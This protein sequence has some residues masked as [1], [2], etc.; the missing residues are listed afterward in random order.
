MRPVL[1]PAVG[2]HILMYFYKSFMSVPQPFLVQLKKRK[3]KNGHFGEVSSIR[4]FIFNC[5]A[6]SCRDFFPAQ[7]ESQTKSLAMKYEMSVRAAVERP[8]PFLII[9]WTE[10]FPAGP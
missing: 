10:D 6:F 1:F 7:R 5:Y 2:V 9:M 8:L 3:K 4:D